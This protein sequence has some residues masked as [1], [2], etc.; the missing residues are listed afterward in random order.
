MKRLDDGPQIR[1]WTPDVYY[2]QREYVSR[3]ELYRLADS[4]AKF[5]CGDPFEPRFRGESLA[6][7]PAS[8]GTLVH[9]GVLEPGMYHL[10]VV[11]FAKTVKRATTGEDAELPVSDDDQDP[12]D[13]YCAMLSSRVAAS[14]EA[15]LA[16]VEVSPKTKAEIAA[17]KKAAAAAK[18]ASAAAKR[19]AAADLRAAKAEQ[20]AAKSELL[21]MAEEHDLWLVPPDDIDHADAIIASVWENPKAAAYLRGEALVS[22]QECIAVY[23]EVAITWVDEMTGVACRALL[24]RVL[25]YPHC[26]VVI[27]LKTSRHTPSDSRWADRAVA[28]WLYEQA[29]FYCRGARLA[30]D[31]PAVFAWVAARNEAPFV[32]AFHQPDAEE[33]A[34]A[35]RT[36]DALL[37]RLAYLMESD[38]WVDPWSLVANKVKPSSRG[39]AILESRALEAELAVEDLAA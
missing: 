15:D 39:L 34:I 29:E 38:E 1:S 20:A 25:V 14:C 30:W 37:Q 32:S 16:G 7:K 31:R 11:P 18:K 24:D 33:L 8:M 3:S 4:V 17:E 21:K 36:N 35:K 2:R 22:G 5:L 13:D 23:S 26:V 9:R 28:E 12:P 27:D 10:A 19:K 6:N